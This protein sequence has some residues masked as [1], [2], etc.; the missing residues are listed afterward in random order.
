MCHKSFR[1]RRPTSD[2]MPADTAGERPV[3]QVHSCATLGKR[4][5]QRGRGDTTEVRDVQRDRLGLACEARASNPAGESAEI[6][7]VGGV[8]AFACGGA[9]GCGVGAQPGDRGLGVG[10]DRKRATSSSSSS[11]S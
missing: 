2:V 11:Y 6:A 5:G 1:A 4:F 10:E 3:Y 7:P 8:G 9:A